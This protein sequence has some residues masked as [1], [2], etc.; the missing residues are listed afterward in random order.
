VRKY[1]RDERK[2]ERRREGEVKPSERLIPLKDYD[3]QT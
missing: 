3:G 2:E 1:K